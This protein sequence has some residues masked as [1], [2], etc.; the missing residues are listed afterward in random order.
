MNK[1]Y[2]ASVAS[3][4]YQA[5]LTEDGRPFIAENYYVVI[6]NAAGRRFAHN[7]VFNGAVVHFDDEEFCHYFEDVRQESKA[8]AEALCD[9][10][11]AALASGRALN[12]DLWV[13]VDPA[14][15]SDEYI[16]QGTEAQRAFLE[17]LAA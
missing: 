4:L 2:F 14:Y 3:D 8:K 15:G 16:S 12:L 11:S 10:V 13:E 6:E 17:R 1:T 9:R 7:V 5:G